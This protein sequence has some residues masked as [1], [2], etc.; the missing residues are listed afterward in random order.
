M[1]P[2]NHRPIFVAPRDDIEGRLQAIWQEL[3][4]TS[5]IGVHDDFY[6]IGG[7]SLLACQTAG[8]N[9]AGIQSAYSAD[10][11]VSGADDR[12]YCALELP[13][14]RKIPKGRRQRRFNRWD[15]C[16]RSI[17]VGNFP[18]FRRSALKLGTD[19]P[20]IGLSIPDELRMRLP[21][22]LEQLA[23]IQASSILDLNK[24][25]PIFLI[26]FSAEGVLAYEIAH[27]FVAAGREVG[28]VAMIDTTCPSQPARAADS[29]NCAIGAYP[30]ARNP[31]RR[32]ATGT[33]PRLRIFS[34]G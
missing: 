4:N 12:E 34:A 17:V 30:S 26:G 33:R 23:G 20:L 32:T 11:D 28:L 31:K 16:L 2:L 27:Q 1:R 21:Y 29:A 7:H 5:P 15:P 14:A 6:A 3:L 10:R 22:N 24:G 19:R 18:V 25:E 13:A 8:E 9:R